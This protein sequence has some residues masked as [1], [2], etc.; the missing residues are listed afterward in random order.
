RAWPPPTR[1][2][3]RSRDRS[4]PARTCRSGSDPTRTAGPAWRGLSADSDG[5]RKMGGPL[6]GLRVVDF[7]RVLSGP[8]CTKTLH[9]LGAEVIK[10]EPPRPDVSRFAL[11]RQPGLSHYYA[12][13]NSG[14][15]A[16]S[17]DLNVPE[18]REIAM[19]LCETADVVVENFRAGTLAY[20]GLDYASVSNRNPRVV[21]ASISGYGQTGPWTHRAAYAPT[22][23]AENGFAADHFDHLGPALAAKRHDA[24]S[25][26]DVY[27]GLEAAVAVLAA[28]HRRE[29]TGAGQYVDISMAA[30]MLAVNE[31]VH[32]D[33]SGADLGAEPP[34]L[35]PSH[36]RF[37]S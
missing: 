8:H 21:Y 22:V 14:K 24:F 16:V 13:Q 27:P 6:T 31:R 25:H 19:R 15:R 30:T 37:F 4:G 17:L 23:H 28:L 34:A 26:A 11:P 7:S 20:F 1:R 2:C 12:Q 35:G 18:A 10:V 5:G 9:D 32:V 29:W 33:L 3:A 36:A